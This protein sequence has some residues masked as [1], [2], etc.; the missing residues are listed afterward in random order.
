MVPRKE[1]EGELKAQEKELADDIASLQ[2]KV[3]MF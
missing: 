2:K 3:R 1:M